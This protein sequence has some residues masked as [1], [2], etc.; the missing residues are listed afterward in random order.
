MKKFEY[1]TFE[2]ST[3]ADSRELNRFGK[4]GWELVS[5]SATV[6]RPLGTSIYSHFYTFKREIPNTHTKE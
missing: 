5:H 3:P 1:F 4:E 2:R 6:V